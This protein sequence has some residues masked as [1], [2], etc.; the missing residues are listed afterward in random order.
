MTKQ[1]SA[2]LVALA[3]ASYPSMQNRDPSPIIA[4]WAL[5]LADIPAE[6]GK[7]AV[8][9]VC[10]QSEFFPS[11]AQIVAASE[12][13]DPRTDTTPSAAEA[14]EEVYRQIQ[15]TGQYRQPA[16]TNPVIGRAVGAMGWVELCQGE[17]LEADRAHFLRIY[18]SMRTGHKDREAGNKALKLS[19]MDEIVKALA[20]GMD[21]NKMLEGKK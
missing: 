1:E 19:G 10:R 20:G 21:M 13:V 4:A 12:L 6:V 11:V 15:Y 8:V 18:E 3:S 14:W 9:K 17:N 16:W 2:A 5:M 7:A